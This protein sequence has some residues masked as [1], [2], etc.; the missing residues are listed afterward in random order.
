MARKTDAEVL[1][2]LMLAKYTND[3]DVTFVSAAVDYN[4]PHGLNSEE[5]KAGIA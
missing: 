3:P 1:D 4:A 5:D 2:A